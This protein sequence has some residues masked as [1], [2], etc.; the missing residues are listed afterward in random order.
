[1]VGG[2]RCIYL[3]ILKLIRNV[4]LFFIVGEIVSKEKVV[5]YKMMK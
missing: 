2:V 4:D 3:G 5:L 1:M